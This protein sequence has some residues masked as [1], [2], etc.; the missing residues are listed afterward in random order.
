MM[1]AISGSVQPSVKWWANS[2]GR[3]SFAV[4]CRASS[5]RRTAAWRALRCRVAAPPATRQ[6]AAVPP[7]HAAPARR[8]RR[9]KR[10]QQ[11]L[12]SPLVTVLQT[13]CHLVTQSPRH[14]S[15]I[16]RAALKYMCSRRVPPPCHPPGR[17]RAHRRALRGFCTA[18]V[19][20]LPPRA[21]RMCK[22][23]HRVP[24]PCRLLESK[25]GPAAGGT[26]P[27]AACKVWARAHWPGVK[28]SAAGAGAKSKRHAPHRRAWG[29]QAR[30]WERLR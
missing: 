22:Y 15:L 7:T 30:A 5:T 11:A 1:R 10:Q 4:G 23:N 20:L 29:R 14:A 26:P 2:Y 9:V 6:G 25:P 3:R 24:P 12:A 18:R 16:A 21:A 28:K 17:L 19:S 13:N 8:E 27:R